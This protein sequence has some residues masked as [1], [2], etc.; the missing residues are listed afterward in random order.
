MKDD[1]EHLKRVAQ[2]TKFLQQRGS[3]KP[4]EKAAVVGSFRK[5]I[6]S[7]ESSSKMLE[8]NHI[9]E[10]VNKKQEEEDLED[11]TRS[12]KAELNYNFKDAARH[13]VADKNSNRARLRE[14]VL[15]NLD[16]L[17]SGQPT[18]VISSMR[19]TQTRVTTTTS[20]MQTPA[21]LE[22]VPE[23]KEE[24]K[25]ELSCE[26]CKTRTLDEKDQELNV[27]I[28]V[29]LIK[30]E[31]LRRTYNDYR[32]SKGLEPVDFSDELISKKIMSDNKD[33]PHI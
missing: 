4:A 33:R 10:T 17:R 26:M 6:K 24:T 19:S 18:S 25:D 5:S 14:K 31:P 11:E 9:K 1:P 20:K 28:N 12:V 32:R 27:R 16:A 3:T 30:E 8:K 13:I 2:L 23:S 15:H 22:A 29:Q 7:F 21:G